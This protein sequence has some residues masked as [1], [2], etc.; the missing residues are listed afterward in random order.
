MH[1]KPQT[2]FEFV[3]I[4]TLDYLELYRKF[5]YSQQES[6]SLNHIAYLE[7]GEKKLDYSEVE[8]LH[9][10]YKTNFQK[11]IEYNIHDVELVDRIDAKMQLIDM[12]LA[13]AYDAKVNYNDVFTQVRMW[14]T[15]IHND[16]MEQNIIVPQNVHTSKY[17]QLAH[18]M[19][20]FGNVM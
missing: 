17:S 2:I 1:N 11:F 10:L 20:P 3:G 16:L 14:D 4:A 12:A 5:T 8:S 9:Q 18:P 15:L 6:F 19:S 13:L 7:L